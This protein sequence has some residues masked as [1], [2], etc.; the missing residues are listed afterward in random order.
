MT[1][2]FDNTAKTGSATAA[3]GETIVWYTAA[4]GGSVTT[5]PSRTAVGTS[6]AYAG[7]KVTATGCEGPR[8]LVTVTINPLPLA[9]AGTNVTACFDNTAKT[10]SATVGA[11]ETLIW[12]T[13]ATGGSVTTAPSRTAVGTS[14]AY[15]GAKVTATGCEGPRTLVTVTINPLPLAPAGT[16]VTACFDNTAKTGSATVGAGETLIWYTAATGGTVT[17]APSRTAVGTSSAYAGAK[18]TATGCEGPRT[19]V[20]VTINPLPV[21]VVNNPSNICSP[22]TVDLT[23]AAITAGSTLYGATL[24]YWKNVEATIPLAN[25]TM[26]GESGTYYIKATT[27]NNCMD[28][29]SVVVTIDICAK[30]LCTY[31]QGYYGNIGGMSCA[32]DE[33]GVFKQYTTKELIA[34]ALASY[35]GT[36]YV[37]IK[38]TRHVSIMNNETDINALID[39]MPGGGG[40]SVLPSNPNNG[41]FS[42]SSLPN[43]MLKK[44]NINNT[45]LAQTIALGLNIGINGMLGDFELKAGTIAIATPQDGCGSDIPKA[46]TCNPD[47]TVNNEYKRYTISAKVVN[48]LSVKTVQGLYALAN[49]ALGGG[50]TNGLSLSEIAGTVDLINNAFDECRIFVGYDVPKMEC[51]VLTDTSLTLRTVEAAAFTA[52][53]VPFKD[54]LTIKYD[55]D[56]VSSVKIEVFNSQGGLVHSVID[57]K[58]YLNKEIT[59]TLSTNSEQEEVFMVQIT[60]DRGTTIKK[61]MSS[62]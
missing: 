14:S 18:V 50:D 42:I 46:R 1:A 17:T 43:S 55:F 5:A 9:P 58:G 22:L 12:Y 36:M 62:N 34:K 41:L 7:A 20:T 15:A 33:L 24:T 10:G 3:A 29:K 21:L 27:S 44:G 52:Y 35:G 28:V 11:G 38:D 59:I 4:T 13:A 54:Q 53:P 26:V 2:C 47:G 8:T 40:S 39:V 19:L 25:P 16:N 45:L 51:P 30:A 37:G 31:T 49:Q 48:A 61:V 60:T 32:P 57:P 56:Y 6:S 23:A